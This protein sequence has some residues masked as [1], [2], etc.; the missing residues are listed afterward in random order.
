MSSRCHIYQVS[1]VTIQGTPFLVVASSLG[2]HVW[3]PDGVD[4]KFYLSLH[5]VID[6]EEEGNF[7]RGIANIKKGFVC[8]GCSTGCVVI[9]STPTPGE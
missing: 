6:S 9:L 2:I 8:V 5:A 4:M 7:M 3:T 1:F